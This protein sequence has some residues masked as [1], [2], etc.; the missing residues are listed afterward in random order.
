[1]NVL[2][3]V[4]RTQSRPKQTETK[5]FRSAKARHIW[6]LLYTNTPSENVCTEH[7]K[8]ALAQQML[9]HAVS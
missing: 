7:L 6:L 2:Y 3:A 4:P 9:L 8:K 1:M 5:V